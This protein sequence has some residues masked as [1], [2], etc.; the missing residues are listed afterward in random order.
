MN[1]FLIFLKKDKGKGVENP[2]KQI[3]KNYEKQYNYQIEAGPSTS[4]K[5]D[6]Y[7]PQAVIDTG[8]YAKIVS[9][10]QNNFHDAKHNYALHHDW[11]EPNN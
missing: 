10:L 1:P 11:A 3:T 6:I 2:I 8:N 4:S 7:N 9:L 5:T